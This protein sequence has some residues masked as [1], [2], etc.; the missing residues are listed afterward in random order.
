[1]GAATMVTP[2]DE[3]RMKR[4]RKMSREWRIAV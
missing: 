2:L 1:M 4:K 3:S